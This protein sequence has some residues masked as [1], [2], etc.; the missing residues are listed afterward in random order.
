VSRLHPAQARLARALLGWTQAMC[1]GTKLSELTILKFEKGLIPGTHGL[2]QKQWSVVA[3]EPSGTSGWV[4]GLGYLCSA[5][6]RDGLTADELILQLST[7][8]RSG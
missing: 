7:L 8:L 2:N 1:T 5:L 4:H 3:G 6:R